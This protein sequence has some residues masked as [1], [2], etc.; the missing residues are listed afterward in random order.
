[1]TLYD[2]RVRS[3]AAELTLIGGDGRI[4]ASSSSDIT[5][6]IPDQ[7]PSEMMMLMRNRKHYIGLDP[8][9]DSGLYARAL[10]PVLSSRSDSEVY[11]LQAMYMVSERFSALADGV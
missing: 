9:G 5:D 4:V 10:V 3:G 7:P 11:T 8:I 6:I 1:M 2:H